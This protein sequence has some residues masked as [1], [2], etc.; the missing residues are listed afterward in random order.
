MLTPIEIN[1]DDQLFVPQ[2]QHPSVAESAVV[3]Y[4]CSDKG[5]GVYAYVTLKDGFPADTK[6]ESELRRIVRLK[7]AAYAIP[8]VIQVEKL[9]LELEI[10]LS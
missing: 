2:D 8:D 7:I 4:P 10:S 6:T 5:E 1:A 9:V 3:G